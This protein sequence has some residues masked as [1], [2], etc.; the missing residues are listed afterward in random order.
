[1]NDKMNDRFD[2]APAASGSLPPGM[3]EILYEDN[4]LLVTVK[5][6]G[7][8]TQSD[9]TGDPSLLELCKEYIRVKYAKPGEAFIGL[10]HRLDRPVS[11]VICFART[12]KAAGRLCEQFRERSLDKFYLA[13]IEGH[14]P[15]REG[16]LE[17]WLNSSDGR[18]RKTS[19]SLT[20]RGSDKLARLR[21]RIQKESP[22]RQL[23]EIELLTGYKHQI[24]AQLSK[25]GCP[26][27]GDYK[28]DNRKPPAVFE[29]VMDGRAI[30]LHARLLILEHPT[31]R[32]RLEFSAPLPP[33]WPKL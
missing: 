27:V 24:R 22:R 33:H 32:E 13:L 28:Y 16:T 4:H 30:A 2:S 3:P 23:V 17:H 15:Q 6:A 20:E 12:S 18:R 5:P 9:E 31:T 11:G 25:T 1:M 26:I 10:V 14:L 29:K 21:Y 8:L 19:A 7:L